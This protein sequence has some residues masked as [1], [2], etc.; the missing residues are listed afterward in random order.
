MV[1]LKKLINIT[2]RKKY[3]SMVR[4][5]FLDKYKDK[6]SKI[7]HNEELILLYINSLKKNLNSI[8]QGYLEKSVEVLM[9]KLIK[10]V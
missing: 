8:I 4:Q 6:F 9:Q 10:Y 7:K 1:D 3:A 5:S 2:A